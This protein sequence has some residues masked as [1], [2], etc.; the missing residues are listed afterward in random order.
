MTAEEHIRTQLELCFAGDVEPWQIETGED[1]SLDEFLAE[2]GVTMPA[3]FISFG[4]FTGDPE[5]FTENSHFESY[6]DSVTVYLMAIGPMR[7]R[8]K[9]FRDWMNGSA[10]EGTADANEFKD[11]DGEWRRI[12]FLSGDGRRLAMEGFRVFEILLTIK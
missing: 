12:T 5:S 2:Q 9:R 3:A 8:V 7:D 6:E 1:L 11:A 4:G 10:P